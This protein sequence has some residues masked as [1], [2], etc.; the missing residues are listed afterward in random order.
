MSEVLLSNDAGAIIEAQEQK[1]KAA[2]ATQAMEK[3]V[4]APA[5]EDRSTF[6]SPEQEAPPLGYQPFDDFDIQGNEG[7]DTIG[8]FEHQ[9]PTPGPLAGVSVGG[10]VRDVARGIT[11][12]PMQVLGGALD[13][14]EGALS[15]VAA[16]DQAASE[17][18]GLPKLQIFDKE[19]NFDPGLL[20]AQEA[21]EAVAM[22]PDVAEAET[23]T[24]GLVR[25]TAQFLSG[26]ATGAKAI[27][28]LKG[29]TAVASGAR[30]S[31]AAAI[32]DFA[33][34]DG[35]EQRLSDL[36]ESNPAL[37]N[38]ITEYLQSDQ[39]D[40][41]LE[42]R[43]KNVAEGILTDAA[44][45]GLVVGIRSIRQARKAKVEAG[46]E[47]YAE[48]ADRLAR[49]PEVAARPSADVSQFKASVAPLVARADDA[50]LMAETEAYLKKV[51]GDIS[52]V[53]GDIPVDD[54]AKALALGKI[55]T[56]TGDVYVNW[57]RMNTAEDVKATIQ[58]MADAGQEE[59]TKAKR[60]KKTNVETELDADQENAWKLLMER[61]EGQ[62]MNASESLAMRRLWAS[63][64]ERL[65]DL[66]RK[67]QEAPTPENSFA[68]RR[69]V[70][71][72]GT[73][74][75][76]AI[77][78]RTETAR[79]LQQWAIPAGSDKEMMRS[80]TET[81]DMF[82]GADVADN[83]ASRIVG[84]A[85][86]GNVAA[87]DNLSRKSAGVATFDA[88]SEYWI[89]A[90]LSGP[91]THLVN[92]IGNTGVI[93]L[94]QM[95]RLAA[96]GVSAVRGG[97][98]RIMAREAGAMLHGSIAA[99]P[100]AWRYM[101][102]AFKEGSSGFGMG[103]IEAPR[104]RAISS[105]TLGA[106]RN[107]TFNKVM[108]QPLIATGI[109]KLGALVTIP[110]RA[111]GAG[112]EFFKTINYRMEVHAQAARQAAD[113]VSTGAIKPTEMKSRMADLIADPAESVRL[114]AREMAQY[115]TFTNDAGRYARAITD[116][117]HKAP[118]LRFIVPFVNT[119][120][121]IL[122]FA[123]ER[124]PA[125]PL[126]GDVRAD[127][128]AGGRRADMA[129]ARMSLG[130]IAM[131]TAYDFAAKGM[132]TGSGPES[133]SEKA[134]LRRSGW[135]PYSV[136]VGDRYFAYNR[137]DPLG[138]QLGVAAEMAEIANNSSID[139]GEDYD[140]AAY[141][142]IGA[143]GQNMMDKAYVRGL[144]DLFTAL[145][146]PERFAPTY[147]ERLAAS[148]VP[149]LARE[150]ATATSPEMRR[151]S[152]TLEAIKKKIPG[153]AEDVP[154]RHDLWGRPIT[155]Q[156]GL[157]AAYD[158]VSPIYSSVEAVEPIDK[159]LMEIGY[160]P[161]P[162]TNRITIS[163]ESFSLRNEPATYEKYM[164]LQGATSAAELPRE[165]K[166]NGEPTA[167][168]ARMNEYGDRDLR[169]MLNDMVTGSHPLSEAYAKAD[170]EKRGKMIAKVIRDYRRLARMR[171]IEENPDVFTQP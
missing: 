157:G 170:S 10:V 49:D 113:E 94:Q 156:S 6:I 83:L 46:A 52:G 99:L 67:V 110:G 130:S 5:Y 117:K 97:T 82:G 70:A 57:N 141:R 126:L 144:S 111:L 26:F 56:G 39:E 74:Q 25:G 45:S 129:I 78:V 167:A 75:K 4:G 40:S 87:I 137:L 143:V 41:E 55:E 73:I 122:R 120:A 15:G 155:Y 88:V 79:A 95:E 154:V 138:M 153:L 114:Q 24:G 86:E 109:D 44:I 150:V 160:F 91:K 11:E 115:G 33:A 47:T 119:P 58:Q 69:A 165:M 152:D 12:A 127:I 42:G 27:G 32:S 76:H 107:R 22:V 19:G 147:F 148:F 105:E 36:I 35:H 71:L 65:I 34:F 164:V 66:A 20:S 31:S 96:A 90:I 102:R 123:T 133:R 118:V 161:G 131:L 146:E 139:P 81:V 51:K 61:R 18:L 142:M 93:A 116:F 108:N 149:T 121:N 64:G 38:P 63:S 53:A 30:A 14:Y 50:A 162:P 1:L 8:R 68:F 135:Q 92:A 89:N 77:A 7:E 17:A 145:S 132:I 151:S 163:G 106:T 13:A 168:S 3:L 136:K 104:T 54:A 112:D 125:A 16:F 23:V 101:G 80:I 100:D 9:G 158:A 37:S 124:S 171:L 48:A 169:T 29:A 103:K 28:G 62:T 166:S 21:G 128:R 72:H 98:D 59:I 60:G 43:L 159:E 134:A 140:E 2:Q 84:L 85:D